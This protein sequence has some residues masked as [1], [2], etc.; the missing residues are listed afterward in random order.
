[1]ICKFIGAKAAEAATS[2]TANFNESKKG[3]EAKKENDDAVMGEYYNVDTIDMFF[4]QDTKEVI[5]VTE[6]DSINP[7]TKKS[8]GGLD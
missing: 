2:K 8:V 7:K 1:M 5:D 6:K 4:A 3:T